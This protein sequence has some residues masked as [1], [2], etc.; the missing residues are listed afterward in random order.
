[1]NHFINSYFEISIKRM[2]MFSFMVVLLIPLG[3]SITSLFQNS[4]S[5]VQQGMV[6]KHQLISEAMV[7]PFTLFITSRQR[8]LF[9]LGNEI[10]LIHSKKKDAS[11]D[12]GNTYKRSI[13]SVIDKYY[14]SYE[15]LASVSFISSD[16][17]TKVISTSSQDNSEINYPDYSKT[18]LTFLNMGDYS[19]FK[20]DLISPAF[21]SKFTKKPVVLLKHYIY[22]KEKNNLEMGAIV[23]EVSLKYIESMCSKINFGV[24]GH[25]ATVDQTGHVIAHT[26]K[27]W[28]TEIR[29]LSYI[30]IVEKM[31]AG[32][33]GTTEFYSP[34]LKADM[35]A[36][37][38]AIPALGWGVMI[39]QPK[40]E[41]TQSFDSIRSQ[42]Y[43]WLIAG[44]I[45][46]LFIAYMLMNKITSPINNLVK[47][48]KEIDSGHD[49]IG[50]G[51]IPKNSPNEIKQLWKSFADLLIGLQKSNTEVK[52]L[53]ISLSEDVSKA[54]KKLR[55]M[56]KH[57]YDLSNKDYLT[58]IA[59]RRFYNNHLEKV[60]KG[61]RGESVGIIAIDL[62]KFK[63]INDEYGHDAGD[64]VLKHISQIL[65]DSTREADLVARLGGD[66]FAVYVKNLNDY[67]LRGLA[68]KIRYTVERSPFNFKEKEIDLTVS[69]GLINYTKNKK[70]TLTFD[71]LLVH[72]D[73]AMYI[74]KRNGRNQVSIHQIEE[75]S[76]DNL[77]METI[78]I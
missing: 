64:L 70:S 15:D 58:N 69:V 7:E 66:E 8:S 12:E 68:E 50:L 62:D 41:L 39:P 31:M 25:C 27:K 53:N 56:N 34:S 52:R 2:I 42:T 11:Y 63:F 71:Q 17:N 59:N 54:T 18:A 51:P 19:S 73:K 74:S 6:E 1:M 3:F 47:R 9:T 36:G 35:V 72:A 61:K 37:Y 38:S 60:L 76:T 65:R 44:I 55:D 77:K 30:S 5:Q 48:T 49:Y 16:R 78:T 23:A 46:A 67:D 45:A 29:D 43:L 10:L 20:G 24:M 14:N 13:Q 4:W 26:N 28:V 57:L 32:L 22:I 40:S 21:I 33:S 75:K